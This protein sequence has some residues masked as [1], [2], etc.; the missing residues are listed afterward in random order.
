MAGVKALK[1]IAH[2]LLGTFVSRNNDIGGY[3][4]LGVLRLFAERNAL[5][6]INI[7]LLGET[8]DSLHS[9]VAATEATYVEWFG[10]AIAKKGI[11]ARN[12]AKAEINLRF[13]TLEEFPDVVRDPRG[14]P[15]LC[16]ITIVRGN[17][18]TDIVSKIGCCES[19]DP[20]KDRRS[21]RVDG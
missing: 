9:T 3:W 1:G 21:T 7:D 18:I 15:Y 5:S 13:S 19:H 2:G 16:T 14:E 17:G 6:E 11:D 10:Q 8:F 20:S 12:L 4:G